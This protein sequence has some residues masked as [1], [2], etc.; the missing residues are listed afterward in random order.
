MAAVAVGAGSARS[1]TKHAAETHGLSEGSARQE[2]DVSVAV[3]DGAGD[4]VDVKVRGASKASGDSG[5]KDTKDAKRQAVD[6]QMRS[7]YGGA[8][9]A[10][11]V[12]V[13]ATS[14]SPAA[15]VVPDGRCAG[16]TSSDATTYTG[17]GT[18]TGSGTIDDAKD[19]PTDGSDSGRDAEAPFSGMREPTDDS[20]RGTGGG[21]E[22]KNGSSQ[23]TGGRADSAGTRMTWES[24]SSLQEA[25]DTI[26]VDQTGDVVIDGSST[27]SG[28]VSGSDSRSS[29]GSGVWDSG[30]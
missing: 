20:N 3:D 1:G 27:F 18:T 10:S 11:G 24:I 14:E 23:N 28:T 8:L 7:S 21:E 4:E 5:G 17:A 16:R 30:R 12:A 13:Q 25:V 26:E 6:D 15:T 19:T 29:S 22:A 9:V 2:D